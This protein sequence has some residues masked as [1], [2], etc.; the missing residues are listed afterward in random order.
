MG[1]RRRSVR[2]AHEVV[3][4]ANVALV[5]IKPHA[6]TDARIAFVR[7]QLGAT[8]EM[9]ILYG[10]RYTGYRKAVLGTCIPGTHTEY[11]PYLGYIPVF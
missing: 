4:R 9:C 3:V 8:T 5:F 10:S 7:K 2:I 1:S 11:M 6:T